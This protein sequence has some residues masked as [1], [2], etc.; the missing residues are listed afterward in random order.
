MCLV[1][2]FA[3]SSQNELLIL[4]RPGLLVV[5]SIVR[6]QKSRASST[7][8]FII[9]STRSLSQLTSLLK[10]AELVNGQSYEPF[11]RRVEGMPNYMFFPGLMFLRTSLST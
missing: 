9:S 10:L 11:I 5:Y 1:G 8:A 4:A 2:V 6:N 7:V 3:S